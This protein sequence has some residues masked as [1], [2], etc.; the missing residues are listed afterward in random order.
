MHTEKPQKRLVGWKR[1][2]MTLADRCLSYTAATFTA[3]SGLA[4]LLGSL[5]LLWRSAHRA[6]GISQFV[7]GLFIGGAV[8][9]AV[10]MGALSCA[11]SMLDNADKI[12]RV[13]LLTR[14]NTGH[15]PEAETLVRASD[16]FD[17]DQQ[18]ELLRAAGQSTQ[19]PPE[20]LLRATQENS[21]NG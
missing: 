18:S 14:H 13:E 5:T 6:G 7:P 19:T 11:K 15:L 10:G 16:R 21:R 9:F 17:T 8:L 20:Q 2:L 4:F 3:C 12:E 1:Y